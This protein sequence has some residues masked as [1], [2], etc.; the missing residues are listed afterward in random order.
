MTYGTRFNLFL[1]DNKELSNQEKL[2]K[3]EQYSVGDML[4]LLR[5]FEES[6]RSY[7]PEII[8]GL[9]TS[10]YNKGIMCI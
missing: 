2:N 6:P 5:N 9:Y 10:L 1:K 4:T 7:E 3:L 8:K